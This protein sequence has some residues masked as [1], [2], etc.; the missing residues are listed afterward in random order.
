MNVQVVLAIVALVLF[1]I[2]IV[3]AEGRSLT[4]VGGAF[5]S[6]AFLYAALT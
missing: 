3:Q 1:I 4:A 6:V 2:A 5:L